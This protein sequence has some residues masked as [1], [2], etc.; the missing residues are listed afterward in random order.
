M[1]IWKDIT[2]YEGLYKVSNQGRLKRFYKYGKEKILKPTKMNCG[3]LVAHLYKNGVDEK[4]LVHR[5]VAETF[6]P[7]PLNLSE[8]NHKDEDKT[9]NIVEN[10]E[11]CDRSYNVNYGDRNRKVSKRNINGIKS[12]I[13]LQYTKSGDFICEWPSVNEVERKLGYLASNIA[14]CCRGKIKSAYGFIWKYKD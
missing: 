8:V 3:Y 6:L 5:I 12:K 1:E 9:N 7:N 14:S 11:W 10:L 4:K 2:D 13:T